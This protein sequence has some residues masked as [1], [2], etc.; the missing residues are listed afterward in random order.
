MKNIS[1]SLATDLK[2]SSVPYADKRKKDMDSFE[3]ERGVRMYCVYKHISPVGKVYIG[4]TS[5]NPLKRWRNGQ[6]YKHNSH[7]YNAILKYGWVNFKHEILFENLT[8]EEAE[9]KEIELIAEYKSNQREFGYNIENGGN[10]NGKVSEE[11]KQKMR[12]AHLGVHLSESHKNALKRGRANRAIQ[13]NTG[14]HLTDSWKKAVS[15]GLS[16]AVNQYDLHGNFIAS[17][18]SQT[19]AAK[20]TGVCGSNIMRCCKGERYRAGGYIWRYSDDKKIK[21]IS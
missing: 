16:I 2:K 8:K 10:C 1:V 21:Q 20:Q 13:P 19:E 5:M 15:E 14:K 6:G 4:I 7:F 12:I 3:N 18:P 9:K 11:S 17:Y